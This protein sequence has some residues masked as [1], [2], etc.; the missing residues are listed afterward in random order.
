[1][2]QNAED[3]IMSQLDSN[4]L[5]WGGGPGGRHDRMLAIHSGGGKHCG[6]VVSMRGMALGAT[7]P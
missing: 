2:K 4:H 7:V 5:Q 1:M 3:S 6:Q